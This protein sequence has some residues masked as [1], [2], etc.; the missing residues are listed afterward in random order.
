MGSPTAI[1]SSSVTLQE[2]KLSTLS[3]NTVST[4]EKKHSQLLLIIMKILSYYHH[5]VFAHIRAIL[6][7]QGHTRSQV[8]QIFVSLKNWVVNILGCLNYRTSFRLTLN[9]LEILHLYGLIF[10]EQHWVTGRLYL[11]WW[12]THLIAVVF[13]LG[14]PP[15]FLSDYVPVICYI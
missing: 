5:L 8:I 1:I 13:V 6:L 9:Y 2:M 15:Y 3:P 14:F 12:L 10:E 11:C 7:Q 4:R